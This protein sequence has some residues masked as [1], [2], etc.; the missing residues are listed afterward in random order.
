MVQL[1]Y[2]LIKQTKKLEMLY[3]NCHYCNM[4]I[5]FNHGIRQSR[6]YFLLL[7]YLKN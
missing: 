6:A 4:F 3:L 5:Y 1:E 7:F 2:L